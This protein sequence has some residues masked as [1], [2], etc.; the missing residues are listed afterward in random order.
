MITYDTIE[1][2]Y[3][4][5]FAKMANLI[6][7]NGVNM[8]QRNYIDLSLYRLFAVIIKLKLLIDYVLS[9]CLYSRINAYHRY[10]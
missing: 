9:K 1:E 8:F 10:K 2:L 6:Y 3:I 7:I 4:L 5:V